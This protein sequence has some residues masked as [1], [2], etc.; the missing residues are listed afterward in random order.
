MDK[1]LSLEMMG[2]L[3]CEMINEIGSDSDALEPYDKLV[4]THI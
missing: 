1:R 3:H 2:I 4:E